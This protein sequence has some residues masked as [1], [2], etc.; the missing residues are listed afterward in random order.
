MKGLDIENQ[1]DKLF[2]K[3]GVK[4]NKYE[5]E[6]LSSKISNA[7]LN[8]YDSNNTKTTGLYNTQMNTPKKKLKDR[9]IFSKTIYD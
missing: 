5:M 4:H 3:E 2:R 1:I 6:S 7:N 8:L 9:R